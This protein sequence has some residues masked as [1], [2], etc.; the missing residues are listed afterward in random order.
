MKNTAFI[1]LCVLLAGCSHIDENDRY[2]SVTTDTPAVDTTDTAT[3]VVDMRVL[4]EDYTGQNCVNCPTGTERIEELCQAYG[5]RFIPV[6]IHS[7]P[8]GF[9]GNARFIGLVTDTGNDY[10]DSNSLTPYGQPVAIVNRHGPVAF[11]TDASRW[12]SAVK[13]AASA[14]TDID[15]RLQA[16][17]SGGQ[18]DIS[19]DVVGLG[20]P[21]AGRLQA[22]VLEDGIVALQKMPDGEINYNYVHNHVFRAAVPQA[23]GQTVVLAGDEELTLRL[24]QPLDEQW[25][26]SCLSIVAF[27]Y[28]DDGVRQAAKAKVS[29][30]Q[31]TKE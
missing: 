8:Q 1:L 10:F 7:G 3:T 29:T 30:E 12:I 18:I 4:F 31:E 11:T 6:A 28:D 21:F 20:S 24:R 5:D 27:V 9:A 13:E 25:D 2:I 23:Q 15:L 19:I 26:P 16:V 14:T 22:W 17:L